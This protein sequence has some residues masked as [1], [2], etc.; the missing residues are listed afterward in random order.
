MAFTIENILR[1]IKKELAP[2]FEEKLR[3]Y[4]VKQDKEWLIDQIIRLTLDSQSLQEIDRKIIQE[5]KEQKRKERIAWLQNV[6]LDE[7]KLDQF[8]K[9]YQDY[10]RTKF[11][12]EGYLINNPPA[13]GTQLITEKYRSE[14]G[15]TL[16]LEAKNILF[17]ILFGDEN[18]NT[19]F[20]RVEQELLTITLPRF[21][22]KSIDFM[23]AT[24][25]ISGLGTW[26]D[27][28]S[29]SNDSNAENILL[30]IEYG[31]TKSEIIGDGIVK[32]L[33]IINNLEINEQILY[34][35]MI[36]VEQSTLIT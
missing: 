25:E 19:K 24:T 31:E 12:E 5:Q 33:S 35:R 14:K 4:L 32:T 20:D 10:D 8:I 29:I 26:Q 18:T 21:K 28:D 15:E 3:S 13:K 1:S 2:E 16:L 9:K 11:I 34:A 22:S 36:N 6:K 7:E 17:A 27:P 23:K 30:Q